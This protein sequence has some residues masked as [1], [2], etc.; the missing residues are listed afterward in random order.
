MGRIIDG[1]A[2]AAEL[3][4]ENA[5]WVQKL[6]QRGVT[7]ALAVIL[8]GS[9][10]ASQVYVNAKAKKC[11][12]LGIRSL[13]FELAADTTQEELLALVR[14]LNCDPG[15]DGI[16][17][18]SPPPPQI[19]EEAVVEAIDPAKDV[20]CFHA[21][22]V[23][24]MLIGRT[25]GFFPCTPFGILKLLEKS[26]VDPKGKHAVI[27]GR[28]NIVGKPMMALLLQKAAGANAT[29]TVVHSATPN[30][31][32]YIRSADLVIAA[33][34]RPK[35]VTGDMIKEGA[36]VI[37]VGINRVPNADN[38]GKTKLVGDVDFD[39]VIGKASLVTPVPGGVG[40]MT[41]TML[42][43]NTI[44]SASRRADRIEAE[45]AR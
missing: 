28:S 39:S 35:F 16:L 23:G 34:G 12:E 37:D 41:I 5:E 42:M 11:A 14:K 17:V 31:E 22:N 45:A 33:L 13:K 4:S 10:P 7:P 9:D 6:I 38:P 26:G 21:Q 30:P 43:R 2:I 8:V 29:V 15:V 44:L 1:K 3:N 24:K 36:V 20:D 27:I 18:Q 40:P 25:D 19:D 32:E